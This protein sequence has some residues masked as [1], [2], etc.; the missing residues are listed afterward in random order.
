MKEDERKLLI[1]LQN[2]SKT[3]EPPYVREIIN[4]LGINEKR[5]TY[6]C[7]KWT[8]KGWYDYGVNILAGWLTEAGK[9]ALTT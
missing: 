7:E 3:G 5:A 4:E 2:R 6:I 8:N 1:E 9:Y